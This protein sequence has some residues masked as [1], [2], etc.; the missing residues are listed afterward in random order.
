MNTNDELIPLDPPGR[1]L[2]EEFIEPSGLTQ[3]ALAGHCG[4]PA[5]RLSEIVNGKRRIS[6]EHAIRLAAFFGTSPE[7]WLHL[8]ADYDLRKTEREKGDEI[9]KNITSAAA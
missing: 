3:K 9:R 7:M 8:Q 4:I 5:V 1:I 6:A 2:Y